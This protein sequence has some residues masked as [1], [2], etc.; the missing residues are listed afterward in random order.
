MLIKV[1]S[2]LHFN[3]KKIKK[4]YTITNKKVKHLTQFFITF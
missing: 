3:K 2:Y 1:N 4:S